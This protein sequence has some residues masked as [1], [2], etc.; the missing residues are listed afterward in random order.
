MPA[1][2]Q[3]PPEPE[4]PFT[5]VSTL[6]YWADILLFAFLP[7]GPK[8]ASGPICSGGSLG[9]V[10]GLSHTT[11]PLALPGD[12]PAGSWPPGAVR[13]GVSVPGLVE[14]CEAET[15]PQ[16]EEH[17]PC[18]PQAPPGKGEKVGWTRVLH[19]TVPSR[20]GASQHGSQ[21]DLCLSPMGAGSP[22]AA[23]A[24]SGSCCWVF[25]CQ[26]SHLSSGE[27]A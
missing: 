7:L 3:H 10:C 6:L 16:G 19:C 14:M 27:L 20:E 4:V 13:L 2:P 23:L 11:H 1:Q 25:R 12:V 5:H 9:A 24:P 17:C 21:G 15:C 8:A 18:C 22:T 26:S